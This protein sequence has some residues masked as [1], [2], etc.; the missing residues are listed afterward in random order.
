MVC[1]Y[2]KWTEQNY[3]KGGKDSNLSA[4]LERCIVVFK[5]EEGVKNDPRYVHAWLKFVSVVKC[6][7]LKGFNN[8]I[9]CNAKHRE[10]FAPENIPIW[11]FSSLYC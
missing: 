1:R 6:T 4:V 5:D 3:P 11:P 9:R 2:I 8:S 10:P 7:R